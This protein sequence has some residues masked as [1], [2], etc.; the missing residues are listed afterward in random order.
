MN[1]VKKITIQFP[2]S[3]TSDEEGAHNKN[4]PKP[5]PLT[6]KSLLYVV[7]VFMLC[8]CMNISSFASWVQSDGRLQFLNDQTGQIVKSQWLQSSSG[9]YFLDENGY[10][11]IGWKQIDG[12]WRYFDNNGIMKTGWLE[13]NNDTY[14]LKSDG[15][16]VTGWL[17]QIIDN[18]TYYYYFKQNGKRATGWLQIDGEWYYFLSTGEAVI[19]HWAKI[20]DKWYHFG[21]DGKM[22]TGWYVQDGNYYFLNTQTGERVTGWVTDN[23]G[24]TYYL[25]PDTGIMLRN[26]SKTINGITYIFGN[27]G[28]VSSKTEL[29][30]AQASNALVLN[31]ATIAA[32]NSFNNEV[33]VI[34]EKPGTTTG[35][36]N[37]TIISN[38]ASSVTIGNSTSNSSYTSGT[39][40]VINAYTDDGSTQSP[41]ADIQIDSSGNIVQG[42]TSGPK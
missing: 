9:Y 3:M 39:S 34:G 41:T 13:I 4:K 30:Q 21:T 29:T 17:K 20:E 35:T 7:L 12:S 15:S 16:M 22:T 36:S 8:V 32:N 1:N 18:T 23:K 31:Q 40:N 37:G 14:Y 26:T 38:G 27:N 25:D 42:S 28:A 2:I 10:V 24:L 19:N 11:T 5:K 6:V 33:I